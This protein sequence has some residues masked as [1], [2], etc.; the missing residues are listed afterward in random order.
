MHGLKIKYN[1]KEVVLGIYYFIVEYIYNLDKTLL[2]LE[3]V[4]YTISLKKY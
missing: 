2:E 1:N 3:L 4:G